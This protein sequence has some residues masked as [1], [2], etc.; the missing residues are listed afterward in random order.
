MLTK[1]LNSREQSRSVLKESNLERLKITLSYLSY[2]KLQGTI[3][4]RTFEVLVKY[5][6]SLF[7]ENEVEEKI[8]SALERKLMQFLDSRFLNGTKALFMD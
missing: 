5:A 6:C 4:D 3:E 8:E 1:K 7:L 2:L